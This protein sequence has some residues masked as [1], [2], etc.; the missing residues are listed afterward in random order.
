MTRFRLRRLRRL[1]RAPLADELAIMV[2][3]IEQLNAGQLF[4]FAGPNDANIDQY[5]LRKA[6]ERDR[7]ASNKIASEFTR[8]RYQEAVL[9][10]IEKQALF[11]FI[12]GD[13]DRRTGGDARIKAAFDCCS[14]G[15][16]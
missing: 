6:V 8:C 3:E 5:G 4:G 10:D 2:V 14:R 11:T 12:K 13:E 15:R 7:D 1:L 9:T 16:D